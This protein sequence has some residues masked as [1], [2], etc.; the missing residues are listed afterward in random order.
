MP[1]PT[2]HYIQSR[3]K[4]WYLFDEPLIVHYDAGDCDLVT[5]RTKDEDLYKALYDLSQCDDRIKDGDIIAK[6]SGKH[7]A[8]M[9]SYHLM[10]L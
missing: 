9:F 4:Y 3:S 6:P 8:Q 7:Y 5:G 2:V 10:K 1:R